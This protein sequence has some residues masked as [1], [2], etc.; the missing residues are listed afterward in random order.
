MS[1]AELSNYAEELVKHL[2]DAKACDHAH[3]TDRDL[4]KKLALYIKEN[5]TNLKPEQISELAHNLAK[6]GLTIIA[7]SSLLKLL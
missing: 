4:V 5:E 6:T 3:V 1:I 2:K 7:Q